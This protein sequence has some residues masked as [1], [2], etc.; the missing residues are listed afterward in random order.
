MKEKYYVIRKE[1]TNKPQK[2]PKGVFSIL[3][4]HKAAEHCL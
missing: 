2:T 4:I 3:E 1:K